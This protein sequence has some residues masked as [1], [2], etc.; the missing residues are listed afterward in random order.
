MKRTIYVLLV[1]FVMFGSFTVPALAGDRDQGWADGERDAQAQTG[2][3]AWVV[4]GCFTGGVSYMYPDVFP[5]NVPQSR[6]V[7]KSPEYIAAYTD[8]FL[9]KRKEIIHSGSCI[10]GAIY[11][12]C[13]VLYFVVLIAATPT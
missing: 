12:G 1:I 6:L 2:K 9:Q 13:C 11:W 5:Y 7:G 3:P 10:G 8:G 4:I